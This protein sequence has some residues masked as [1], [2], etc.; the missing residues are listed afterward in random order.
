[1]KLV[2]L[3]VSQ[4][5]RAFQNWFIKSGSSAVNIPPYKPI[6]LIQRIQYPLRMTSRFAWLTSVVTEA[7][8]LT[9]RRQLS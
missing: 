5:L 8:L 6:H 2:C 4:P 3:I 1:M 9:S 7:A